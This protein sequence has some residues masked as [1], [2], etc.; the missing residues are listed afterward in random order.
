M[1]TPGH[2][3]G[4]ARC[5]CASSG[6]RRDRPHANCLDDQPRTNSRDV[7]NELD[8][9]RFLDRVRLALTDHRCDHQG[10]ELMSSVRSQ[11]THSH[12]GSQP[13]FVVVLLCLVGRILHSDYRPACTASGAQSHR[14]SRCRTR[15]DPM[16]LCTPIFAVLSVSTPRLSFKPASA[17][18]C[19]DC[20]P[21]ACRTSRCVQ[22]CLSAGEGKDV[23]RRAAA[24][25][26]MGTEL[27]RSP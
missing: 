4:C 2:M 18:S 10:C 25:D 27:F 12:Q 17:R 13:L 8:R 3:L 15:P 14:M 9:L 11:P 24:V 22:L 7:V 16:R 6:A 20:H 21:P 1:D 19:T 23:L 5:H 26:G